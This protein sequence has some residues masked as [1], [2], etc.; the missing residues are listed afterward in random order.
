[1]RHANY[2]FILL[3]FASFCS[4]N[5]L[6]ISQESTGTISGE[7]KDEDG[8]PLHGALV[9]VSSDTVKKS[10]VT[11]S[12]GKYE[13]SGLAP[14]AYNVKVELS[15]FASFNEPEVQVSTGTADMPFTLKAGGLEEM[16]VVSASKIETP[17][18]MR[19]QQ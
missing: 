11:D 19:Q 7:V 9:V 6:A 15:G 17:L 1:M 18:L 16:M 12:A 10:A 5:N 2:L 14:G 4:F 3:L 8:Q 13:I